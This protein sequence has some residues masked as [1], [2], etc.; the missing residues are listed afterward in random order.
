MLAF[1][2]TETYSIAFSVIIGIGIVAVFIPACRNNEC[3][4]KKAPSVDEVVKTTY[5]IRDKCYKFK[6]SNIECPV[7][8]VIEPFEVAI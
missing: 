5:H 4:V 7:K 6:T 1:L 2:K 3:A 8:G